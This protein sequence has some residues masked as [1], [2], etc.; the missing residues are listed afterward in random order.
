M[1]LPEDLKINNSLVR[2]VY[3]TDIQKKDTIIVIGSYL[4]KKDVYPISDYSN[5][6]S[7]FNG[8]VDKFNEKLVFVKEK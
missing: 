7:Y 5:L 1:T 8:I 6:K 3:A 2:V 4:F